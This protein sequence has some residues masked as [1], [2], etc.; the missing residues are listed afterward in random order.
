MRKTIGFV[1]NERHKAAVNMSVGRNG[2]RQNGVTLAQEKQRM[3]DAQ[4]KK[5]LDEEMKVAKPLAALIG[6]EIIDEGRYES[7]SRANEEE[8]E[9]KGNPKKAKCK[10]AK[11]AFVADIEQVSGTSVGG[12][13]RWRGCISPGVKTSSASG[14]TKYML[15]SLHQTLRQFLEG[16]GAKDELARHLPSNKSKKSSSSS[17]SKAGS[18]VAAEF[19]KITATSALLQELAGVNLLLPYVHFVDVLHKMP[20]DKVAKAKGKKEI[21]ATLQLLLLNNCNVSNLN[22][23]NY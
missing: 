21:V 7:K 3:R 5:R 11:S 2:A 12:F 13:C 19:G 20:K 10:F 18:K 9:V 23:R 15:C 1:E 16:S 14:K 8:L 4:E 22:V 17:S 6:V